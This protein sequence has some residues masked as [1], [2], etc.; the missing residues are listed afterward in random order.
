MVEPHVPAGSAK[1]RVAGVWWGR[2]DGLERWARPLNGELVARVMSEKSV[3]ESW[4]G[5]CPLW[6]V[7]EMCVPSVLKLC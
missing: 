3:W 6:F 7:L 1:A 5:N 2:G 4:W